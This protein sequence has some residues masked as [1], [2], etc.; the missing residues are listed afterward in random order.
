MEYEG[1]ENSFKNLSYGVFGLG[2][3]Q[4]EHFNKVAKV[5]DDKL[6]EQGGKWFVPVGLG[7]DDQWIEDDFTAWKEELWPTL[8][9]FLRDEDDTTMSTPY[10]ASVLEYR[11]IIHDPLDATVDEK[12]RHNVNGHAIVDAQHPVRGPY[13]CL[14]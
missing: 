14:L 2:N 13:W 11:V 10:T 8:D 1:E 12:K 4:Y 9:Q 5:V 3:R 7:D 6:L